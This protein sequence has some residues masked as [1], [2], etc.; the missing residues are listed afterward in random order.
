MF[1]LSQG[2]AGANDVT[3]TLD[4]HD[5][6]VNE[7][8]QVLTILRQRA[9]KA[10][11]YDSFQNEIVDR[12][13]RIGFEVDVRWYETDQPG[14]LIPEINISG[15]V[16]KNFVFDRDRQTAE[17]TSDVLDLGEG[18]VLKVDKDMMKSLEDGTY[19]GQSHQH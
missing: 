15:R 3:K 1:D 16:D 5:S 18:G 19:K 6:E 7:I 2:L 4:V 14:V 12:F 10:H 8:H 17:V 11:N 13:H 9:D